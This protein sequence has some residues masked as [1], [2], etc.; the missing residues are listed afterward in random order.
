MKHCSHSEKESFSVYFRYKSASQRKT[1][2]YTLTRCRE[3]FWLRLRNSTLGNNRMGGELKAE[4]LE[5]EA[6]P[7]RVGAFLSNQKD[8]VGAEGGD[9]GGAGD[10]EFRPVTLARQSRQ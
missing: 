9:K 2:F 5:E 8:T 7:S 4:N 10:P 3:A 1:C 6:E